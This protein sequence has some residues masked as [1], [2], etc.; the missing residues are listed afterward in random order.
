MRLRRAGLRP[1][2][3]PLA[4]G[5]STAHG[6]VTT[7]RGWLVW[8][9]DEHGHV[10]LGEATPLADFGT[11]SHTACEAALGRL[12]SSIV[13]GDERLLD[14]ALEERL[15]RLAPMRL[16]TPCAV[17]AIDTALHD[18]TA[19]REALSL[20]AWLRLRAGDSGPPAAEVAVQ[21]LIGGETPGQVAEATRRARV[22]GFT[23]FKLKLAVSAASRGGARGGEAPDDLH[24]P[25]ARGDERRDARSDARSEGR[26]DLGWDR[27]RVAALR[28]AAGPEACLRLDANEA[29]TWAEA[30]AALE[31]LEPFGIDYVEQP[32]ARGDLESL[33]R[34]AEES[35]V[36]VAADEALLGA[37]LEACLEREAVSILILKPAALGGIGPVRLLVERVKPAGLRLVWSTLLD[38][39]VARAAVWHL[40]AG[41]GPADET[42]G[43]AT[44]DWLARD[45]MPTPAIQA[46]RLGAP[47]AGPGLGLRPDDASD[48]GS[49]SGSGRQ[50]GSSARAAGLPWS[51]PARHFGID[52]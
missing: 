7:R 19:R 50:D 18:L 39:A 48:P 5:L 44:G 35:P 29:W 24:A 27:A 11:E 9:E 40:A 42:H 15:E 28:E 34:L 4:R 41:L 23:T 43:L 10:G 2:A 32:V 6:V 46:G 25:H 1:F 37:G 33:A 38:G 31:S 45:L 8:L 17:A 12:L 20:A 22:A 21:A 30:A 14:L 26:G 13:D 16:Q 3:L 47:G 52:P 36:A 51:G 49:G